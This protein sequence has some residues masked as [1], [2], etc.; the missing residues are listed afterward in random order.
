FL[1]T[2]P[3]PMTMAG[4][5][6]S[7]K[8]TGIDPMVL[9]LVE[10]D[11]GRWEARDQ[12]AL[13][14]A[15]FAFYCHDLDQQVQGMIDDEPSGSHAPGFPL[16]TRQQAE[17]YQRQLGESGVMPSF[18]KLEKLGFSRI[19]DP[20]GHLQNWNVRWFDNGS[21]CVISVSSD[22]EN[23]GEDVGGFRWYRFG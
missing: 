18:Q 3:P 7:L 22:S 19:K 6:V 23:R 9:Q 12:Y 8:P 16:G 10:F 13:A 1:W 11:G 14:P 5:P 20:G 15:R 21:A 2:G 4:R 17:D